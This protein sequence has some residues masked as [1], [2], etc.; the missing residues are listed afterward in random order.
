MPGASCRLLCDAPTT[1][2]RNMAAD[3]ALLESTVRSGERALRFYRWSRPTLSLGY[4]QPLA[5]RTKHQ[6]SADC[7]VVRRTTGGGAI[8]HDAEL[9]YSLAVPATVPMSRSSEDLYNKVHSA[10]IAALSDLQIS[11]GFYA[12]S[13][14]PDVNEPPFLCFERRSANDVIIGNHKI[15]GSAQRRRAGAVLQHGSVLLGRSHAAPQLA[16]IRQIVDREI[17][18]RRLI[19]AWLPHLRKAL[20]LEF[21]ES[22]WSSSEIE[23]TGQI[24]R[25]RYTSEKWTGK[26]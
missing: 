17:D 5:H 4:F 12:D 3:Q 16:G 10:L 25:A 1:G 9:T 24:E 2:S 15:A 23:A 14:L 18:D 6:E 7:D 19:D 21:Y 13:P 8:V 20:R 22:D 11:A 26:R